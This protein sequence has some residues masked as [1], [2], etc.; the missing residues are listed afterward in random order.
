MWATV[1]RLTISFKRRKAFLRACRK[2]LA[3]PAIECT[4]QHGHG[5]PTVPVHQMNRRSEP[6]PLPSSLPFENH[7]HN[8][9]AHLYHPTFRLRAA[10]FFRNLLKCGAA[11]LA[12]FRAAATASLLSRTCMH[13][14]A[15]ACV[16]VYV[17]LRM[18]AC[19]HTCACA[20]ACVCAYVHLC[21]CAPHQRVRSS[22]VYARMCM[23]R[24]CMHRMSECARRG[25]WLSQLV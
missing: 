1:W 9:H 23:H 24:M 5:P 17:H 19:M 8:A 20:C 13:V 6:S 16:R 4:T 10:R 11:L 21:M 7:P 22:C 14:Y 3:C 2:R 15:H 25:S 12:S 18:C